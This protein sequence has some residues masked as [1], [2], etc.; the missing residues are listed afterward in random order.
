[1]YNRFLFIGLGG[2]GGKTLRFLKDQI[3]RWMKEHDIK[4]DDIPGGWQFLH[5][6]APPQ[7]DGKELN[8]R[9]PQLDNHEYVGLVNAATTFDDLQSELDAS[10][11]R[12]PELRVWRVE[13]TGLK[14]P[15]ETGAG[16]YRAVGRTIGAL[17][18]GRIKSE[19]RKK[20]SQMTSA[21]AGN[22][23]ASAYQ[24]AQKADISTAGAGRGSTYVFVI[25]SLAGGTGAGLFNAVCDLIRGDEIDRDKV[26]GIIY[27]SEIF[28]ELPEAH[29]AGV[30]GNG[31]AAISEILNGFWWGGQ[32]GPG[33]NGVVSPIVDRF[34]RAA[35]VAKD[36]N[37]SGP[38]YP[39]LVGLRNAQGVSFGTF[40]DLFEGVG[41][42]L[43][44]WITDEDVAGSFVSYAT[45]NFKSSA[46]D[47]MRGKALVDVGE[48]E[49]I[50]VPP[51]SALGFARVSVGNDHFERF[52]VDRVARECYRHLVTH[53]SHSKEAERTAK[54]LGR[55]DPEAVT[56][57]LAKNYEGWFRDQLNIDETGSDPGPI[58]RELWH[59]AGEV[60][61]YDGPCLEYKREVKE[62][63]DLET[64]R[65]RPASQWR[66]LIDHAIEERFA[67][68]DQIRQDLDDGSRA[69]VSA[70]QERA[71][72]TVSEAMS[73][74]G[75]LVTARL[76][77]DA[78][79]YL[80]KNV[81]DILTN[82]VVPDLK[83]WANDWQN[84][85]LPKLNDRIRGRLRGNDPKIDEYI[86]EAVHCRTYAADALIAVRAAELAREAADRLF[87]PMSEAISDAHKRLRNE[88]IPKQFEFGPPAN[89]FTL[90]EKNDYESLFD[91]WLRQTDDQLDLSSL[92]MLIIANTEITQEEDVDSPRT[93]PMLEVQRDWSPD[94]RWSSQV[95]QN[96][97][98]KI[99]ST[100][101]ALKE[102]S[103]AW[104]KT[105][106]GPFGE[107]F[108]L[109]LRNALNTELPD[110][111][112][113]TAKERQ[114]YQNRFMAHLATA[115]QAS[116]PL[117]DIDT[118]LSG[119]V[120][121]KSGEQ[122]TRH[123]SML[124]FGRDPD[125]EHPMHNRVEDLL[126][127]YIGKEKVADRMKPD[128]RAR[129]IDVATQ[130]SAPQSILA[131]KSVL[132][133]I[134][135]NWHRQTTIGEVAR[136]QFWQ[137]RRAQ[138]LQRF[139][140]C[141][142]AHLRC[143]V[144]GWFTARLLGLLSLNGAGDDI[145][146]Y[147]EGRSP[148][149]FPN[150]LLSPVK[151]GDRLGPVLESLALAY[152]ET[153]A[154]GNLEPLEAYV[155][156]LKLG[157]SSDDDVLNYESVNLHLARW[158]EAGRPI[159]NTLAVMPSSLMTLPDYAS[160]NDRAEAV[161]TVLD[162]EYDRYKQDYD[163]L[164]YEWDKDPSL[165]SRAPLWTGLW[166][167]LGEELQRLS[168][169]VKCHS[170]DDGLG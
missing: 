25:S 167:L 63:A 149:A 27:T 112:A 85:A 98:M 13:P 119:L 118:A 54:S 166:P 110:G 65:S 35:G 131:L 78:A 18:L 7:P 67:L 114:N 89:E 19:L 116:A 124:P 138:Y 43:L 11:E 55:K 151:R 127:P 104:L 31:L 123:F 21:K 34:L 70:I 71:Q 1:M 91:H 139:V 49:A 64:G 162:G 2:S 48:S 22:D 29:K 66:E 5:I 147:R 68:P 94:A 61:R 50:G 69:W 100:R 12:R 157:Q 73:R 80:R 140:P 163:K 126:S 59:K 15:V 155:H 83:S 105:D 160:W 168:N 109:S 81:A 10:D 45:S 143:M 56:V 154:N 44:A 24:K 75:L 145:L 130:L 133:P 150:P 142:Q 6:D 23:L 125:G 37:E 77:S 39:F 86:D 164:E 169:A 87:D 103:E 93:P 101:N 117:I 141:P 135:Q 128:H 108:S 8:S 96:I 9:V 153:A 159:D 165:L 74:H 158:L 88:N 20:H 51:F 62:W 36:L 152:V 47:N 95:P 134:A 170:L 136:Q 84:L 79:T 156:L 26:F 52:A 3:R 120:G 115:L 92:P 41:R 4:G 72:E 121:T 146:I 32:S 132:A 122:L 30:H 40:D 148:A 102:R 58:R 144:R 107:V 137:H 17:H 38:S 57:A 60:N 90:I 106:G 97:R 113:I 129:H 99:A 46:A 82:N 111:P 76:C 33:D 14:I 42:A 53:H 16:Q 28:D 161:A